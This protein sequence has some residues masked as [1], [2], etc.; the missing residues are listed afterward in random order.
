MAFAL[1]CVAHKIMIQTCQN[2]SGNQQVDHK[3][4]G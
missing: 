2:N 4:K 1:K 3:G